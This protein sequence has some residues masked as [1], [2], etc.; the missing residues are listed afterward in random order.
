MSREEGFIRSK[1]GFPEPGPYLRNV[2][3]I[4]K[5]MGAIH[6]THFTVSNMPMMRGGGRGSSV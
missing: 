2:Y 6:V 1:L 3:Q 5:V 4:C